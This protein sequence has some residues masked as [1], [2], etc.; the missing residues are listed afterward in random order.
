MLGFTTLDDRDDMVL[1]FRVPHPVNNQRRYDRA[2][3]FEGKLLRQG[4]STSLVLRCMLCQ[5]LLDK[6]HDRR[7]SLFWR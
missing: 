7:S 5:D 3:D 1:D 6:G 2:P 4:R